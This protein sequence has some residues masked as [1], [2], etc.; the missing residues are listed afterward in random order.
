MY[1]QE[2][3][4]FAGVSHRTTGAMSSLASQRAGEASVSEELQTQQ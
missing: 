2:G 1:A 4:T 3:S